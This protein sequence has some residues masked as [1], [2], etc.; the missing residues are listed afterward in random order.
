VLR[1]RAGWWWPTVEYSVQVLAS[2]LS[3][4]LPSSP[5]SSPSPPP[6]TDAGRRAALER[7]ATSQGHSSI[8][9]WL[10]SLSSL[11]LDRRALSG[12]LEAI[13]QLTPPEAAAAT[14]LFLGF[15]R[16]GPRDWRPADWSAF[17]PDLLVK[18][19]LVPE[20]TEERLL[21]ALIYNAVECHHTCVYLCV[22]VSYSRRFSL[23]LDTVTAFSLLAKPFSQ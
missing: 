23:F 15:V 10:R 5:V 2:A 13:P 6:H 11:N 21:P 18:G 20:H 8:E 12:V 9:A 19:S 3:D 4:P 16:R 7:H 22:G 1:E 17:H 14:A